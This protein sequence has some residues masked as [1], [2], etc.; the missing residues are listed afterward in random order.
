MADEVIPNHGSATH[1][2]DAPF[3]TN[4]IIPN[5]PGTRTLTETSTPTPRKTTAIGTIGSIGSI[6]SIGTL[7]PRA[8]PSKL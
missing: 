8:T 6:G 4:P 7:G 2:H 1:I 5:I 3:A